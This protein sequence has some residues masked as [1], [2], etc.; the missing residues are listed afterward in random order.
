MPHQ[1]ELTGL[2]RVWLDDAFA[3]FCRNR[4]VFSFT[5][6]DLHKILPAPEHQNWWGVLTARLKNAGVIR[7]VGAQPSTRP[8][9]NGRMVSVW[10]AI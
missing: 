5:A 2:K 3:K 8:E 10:E 6:D 1:L 9:A 4:P 7:R